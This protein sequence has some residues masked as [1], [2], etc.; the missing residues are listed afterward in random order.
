MHTG[1]PHEKYEKRSSDAWEYIN[2]SIAEYFPTNVLNK[3]S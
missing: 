3:T 1:F 2:Y